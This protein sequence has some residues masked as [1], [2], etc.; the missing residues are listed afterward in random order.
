[1]LKIFIYVYLNYFKDF[2]IS[3]KELGLGSIGESAV[4]KIFKKFDK[5]NNGKLEFTDALNA[6]KALK[7]SSK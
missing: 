7:S 2:V 6:I 4:R 1:M 5:N 3:V